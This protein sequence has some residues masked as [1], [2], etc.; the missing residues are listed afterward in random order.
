MSNEILTQDEVDTLLDGVPADPGAS[1]PTDGVR[2]YDRAEQERIIRERVVALE[3]VNARFLEVL[4]KGLLAFLR[5]AV[6]IT[7]PPVRV[8]A[9]AD[10]VAGLAL[11]ANLNVVNVKPMNRNALVVFEPALVSM[12]VDTLFGGPGR[13]RNGADLREFTKTE[14]RIMQR[15]LAIVLDGYQQSWTQIYPLAFDYQRTESHPRF[16]AIAAAPELVVVETFSIDFGTGTGAFQICIP[17][18][19]LEPIRDRL[20]RPQAAPALAAD[21]QWE[22]MLRQQMQSAELELSADL[23]NIQLTVRELLRIQVGDVLSVD[24]GAVIPAAVDGIR[25]FECS[26]GALNGQYAVRIDRV[27]PRHEHHVAGA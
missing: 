2:A 6:E 25:M 21:P 12:V 7:I 5:R 23:V 8:I 27:L 14:Q 22:A 24:I 19:T 3:L 10:F 16:A 18:A 20:Q 1:E 11:P 17:Y 13:V 26:Y 9:F 15:M 4:R